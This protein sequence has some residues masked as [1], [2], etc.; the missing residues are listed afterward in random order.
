MDLYNDNVGGG[1]RLGLGVGGNGSS[2]AQFCLSAS[3]SSCHEVSSLPGVHGPAGM[4][5]FCS[6]GHREVTQTVSQDTSFPFDYLSRVFVLTSLTD[7]LATLH[8]TKQSSQ[9]T[10]GYVSNQ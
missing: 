5:S 4:L 6:L 1:R 8:K 7:L 2:Q 3:M 9:G 10:S